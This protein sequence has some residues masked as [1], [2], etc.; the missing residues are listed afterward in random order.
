MTH[1]DV[2]LCAGA[3]LI[4]VPHDSESSAGGSAASASSL[5]EDAVLNPAKRQA[6][7]QR[8]TCIAKDTC[9]QIWFLVRVFWGRTEA[10]DSLPK[11]IDDQ[12]GKKLTSAIEQ[13]QPQELT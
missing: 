9:S 5:P 11:K 13:Q 7:G 12:I 10:G 2:L 6:I 4:E 1:S 3:A 8:H